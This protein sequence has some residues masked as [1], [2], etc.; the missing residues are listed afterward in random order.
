MV[1]H[2]VTKPEFVSRY[3]GL[4]TV[5]YNTIKSFNDLR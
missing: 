4:L 2:K 5:Q 1:R 3:E